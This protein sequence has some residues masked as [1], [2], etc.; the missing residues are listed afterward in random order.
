MDDSQNHFFGRLFCTILGKFIFMQPHI[1]GSYLRV[2]YMKFSYEYSDF[3]Y[4][5]DWEYL[6]CCSLIMSMYL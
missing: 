5:G 2:N 1:H 6:D 3:G 4:K